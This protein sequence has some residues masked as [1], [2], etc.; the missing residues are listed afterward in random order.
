[1]PS[2]VVQPD[3]YI[4]FRAALQGFVSIKGNGT[5]GRIATACVIG[6]LAKTPTE[7]MTFPLV[8]KD[9][10][11]GNENGQVRG[12]GATRIRTILKR[13][14][15][16]LSASSEGGRTSRG[17]VGFMREYVAL[18]NEQHEQL[19]SAPGFSNNGMLEVAEQFWAEQMKLRLAEKPFA[20]VL[21]SGKGLRHAVRTLVGLAKTRA[22]SAG[23]A[24]IHGTV[25]QHLVGAKLDVVLGPKGEELG[26]EHNNSNKKDEGLGRDGDFIIGDTVIHVTVS[27]GLG[28]IDKCKGNLGAGLRP[29]I[30]TTYENASKAEH[31]LEAEAI[32]ERVD[33]LDIEQFVTTNV[34][35][36][37]T[38]QHAD[39][40][41]ALDEIITRYNEIIDEVEDNP[42]LRI[43]FRQ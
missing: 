9:F 16:E 29:I 24:N 17:T 22:Q 34:Y 28:L 19:K 37:S 20:F 32:A 13:H 2:N 15:I 41:A 33:V 21:D 5:K 11:T 43:E 30:I 1:M 4:A 10:T 26:L 40:R 36:R 3:I 35:E 8:A 6:D 39:R 42:S 18:L 38:F 23:G 25:L 12:M 27:A 7:N 14:G 31:L